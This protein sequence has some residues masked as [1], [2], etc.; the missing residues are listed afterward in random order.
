[1]SGPNHP[2]KCDVESQDQLASQ[3]RRAKGETE[4]GAISSRRAFV[5]EVVMEDVPADRKSA[6]LRALVEWQLGRVVDRKR[7]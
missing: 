6:L 3:S 4:N 1:M 7:C 2:Y 5:I